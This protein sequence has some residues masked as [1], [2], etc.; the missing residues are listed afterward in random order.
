[1]TPNDD[2]IQQVAGWVSG[3]AGGAAASLD[4][5]EAMKFL[6]KLYEFMPYNKIAYQT[7]PVGKFDGQ[8]GQHIKYGREV[9]KNQAGTCVDLAIFYASVCQAV[10][11]KPKLFLIPGHCFPAVIMPSGDRLVAVEVSLIGRSSFAEAVQEGKKKV[12]EARASVDSYEVD[13]RSLHDSGIASLDLPKLASD[14]PLK[15][16]GIE[17]VPAM[18][19]KNE[20]VPVKDRKL[21]SRWRGDFSLAIG[22]SRQLEFDT[23]KTF[24]GKLVKPDNTSMTLLEGT[25]VFENDIL[26]L[27]STYSQRRCTTTANV[28]WR[29]TKA[30]EVE[31]RGSNDPRMT[32]LKNLTLPFYRQE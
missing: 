6:Q 10:G 19:G 11:L 14:N 16:W 31:I 25:Y 30:I 28:T 15:E 1:V 26:T 29:S 7:P 32:G 17:R 20:T 4:E 3:D 23:N 8:P 12:D 9:L 5:R 2:V 13:V 22:G 24:K 18:A 21:E 27:T